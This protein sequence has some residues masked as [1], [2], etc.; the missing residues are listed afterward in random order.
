MDNKIAQLFANINIAR[1]TILED[2]QK[3][4]DAGDK[5]IRKN[6]SSEGIDD[7]GEPRNYLSGVGQIDCPVCKSGKLRYTRASYN[8]HVHAACST[9]NC[10]QWME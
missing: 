5:T 1:K 10:V 7:A 3:R 9:D 6:E 4:F 8:G 2:L